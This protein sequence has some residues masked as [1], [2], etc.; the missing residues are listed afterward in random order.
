MPKSLGAQIESAPPDRVQAVDHG[1][2]VRVRTAGQLVEE[3]EQVHADHAARGGVR[4]ERRDAAVLDSR[5]YLAGDALARTLGEAT[6]DA[7]G[8]RDPTG[9]LRPGAQQF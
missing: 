6:P 7:L 4:V 1:L 8:L 5:A 2:D 3:G 9:A